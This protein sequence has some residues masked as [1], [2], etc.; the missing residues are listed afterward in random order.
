[1]DD[2][3]PLDRLLARIGESEADPGRRLA[4]RLADQSRSGAST[5]K[6]KKKPRQEQFLA[7]VAQIV[8]KSDGDMEQAIQRYTEYQAFF[9]ERIPDK[10]SRRTFKH[11]K[12]ALEKRGKLIRYEKVNMDTQ[13]LLDISRTHE[14]TNYMKFSAVF[15]VPEAV[16]MELLDLGVEVVDMQW[17]EIDKNE[18]LRAQQPDIEPKMKSRLVSRGDMET[19]FGRTDSPTV[20]DEGIR[21]ICSFAVAHKVPIYSADLDHGYF[22]GEELNRPLL[23]RQPK[24]GVPDQNVLP[25]DFF[26]AR[27]PI[28]GTKDAGRH[29]YRKLKRVLRELGFQEGFAMT[30][31]YFL[32]NDGKIVVI[33]GTHVDDIFWASLAEG[34]P[35]IDKLKDMLSFGALESVDFRFCGKEFKQFPDWSIRI[36]C[37]ALILKLDYIEIQATRRKQTTLPVTTSER[38]DLMSSVGSLGWIA[39]S[40]R[41]DVVYRVSNLQTT[42]KAATVDEL[43]ECNSVVKFLK[44]SPDDG[45]YFQP[46]VDWDNFFVGVITDASHAQE[47]EYNEEWD[48]LEAFRSKGGK[49]VTFATY[50]DGRTDAVHLHPICFGGANIK[51]V[52]RSTVQAEAYSLQAGVETGDIIRATIAEM[53]GQLGIKTW[54]LDI[55]RALHMR[56]YSDCKSLVDA[57]KRPVQARIVDKRLAIEI[58]ALRQSLWRS[59]QDGPSDPREHDGKPADYTDE[60]EWIDTAVMIVDPLTKRMKPTLLM[61]VLKTGLWDYKQPEAS[62]EEKARKQ[63]QRRKGGDDE[64]VTD[65]SVEG[66]DSPRLAATAS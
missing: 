11:K 65:A 53:K 58:A 23:L 42:M 44:D 12:A 46:G 37:K 48:I 18:R 15:V 17:I 21:I 62:K 63:K 60:V 24:G 47:V 59:R 28:Y 54:E 49:L 30:A 56:W 36:T 13:H 22:Q 1:M 64:N 9:A 55:A 2:A 6:A 57:L 34:L 40:C 7:Q 45:I 51:R 61:Q 20:D 25:S 26:V 32:Q 35:V 66:D 50:A 5:A 41:P 4:K 39:R 27:L 19:Q 52:C 31:L 8:D 10:T 43:K 33:L 3:T 14:W 16:A 38:S 29:L